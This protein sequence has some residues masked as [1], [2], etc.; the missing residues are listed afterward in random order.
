MINLYTIQLILLYIKANENA[1][2][3]YDLSW[4]ESCQ[5]TIYEKGGHYGWHCDSYMK[6]Y[7]KP[8]EPNFMVKLENYQSLFHYLILKII[9]VVN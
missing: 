5:F 3:N 9:K 6:P 2:W 1:Q 8:S 4:A 7:D